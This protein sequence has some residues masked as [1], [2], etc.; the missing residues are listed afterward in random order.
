[1]LFTP[2]P[3]RKSSSLNADRSTSYS[4]RRRLVAGSTSS[5]SLT[6]RLRQSGTTVA[7]ATDDVS[8]DA[9]SVPL[10]QEESTEHRVDAAVRPDKVQAPGS[11]N[12]AERATGE[13]RIRCEIQN[14]IAYVTGKMEGLLQLNKK[15]RADL[16]NEM[17]ANREMK[18]SVAA[19]EAK[20]LT[21]ERENAELRRQLDGREK[22][23]MRLAGQAKEE[24]QARI[25]LEAALLES[26]R[27]KDSQ[28]DGLRADL[29]AKNAEIKEL[30]HELTNRR[31]QQQQQQQPN[32]ENQN[33]KLDRDEMVELLARVR[34]LEDT[35]RSLQRENAKV[36]EL[37]RR[38]ETELEL[39]KQRHDS[40][41]HE[42]EL[43]MGRFDLLK[44]S[45]AQLQAETQKLAKTQRRVLREPQSAWPS[46]SVIDLPDQTS[47]CGTP[48]KNGIVQNQVLA[49]RSNLMTASCSRISG[50]RK[51]FAQN[52]RRSHDSEQSSSCS[53]PPVPKCNK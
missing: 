21:A 16:E 43:Q 17:R 48:P 23:A 3:P 40:K 50:V 11:A 30:E 12:E 9:L 37:A 19:N 27:D 15:L 7:Q 24:W 32:N 46:A 53:L 2:F 33:K 1:M 36:T 41:C 14:G 5:D 52:R 10:S 28:I 38:L 49:N 45:Y 22:E 6:H 18:D 8:Y 34:A 39:W 4:T 44:N 26:K 47:K 20:W 13:N 51:Q 35:I 25:N 42:L 29:D 31:Q